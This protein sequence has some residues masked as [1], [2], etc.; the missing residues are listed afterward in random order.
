MSGNNTIKFIARGSRKTDCLSEWRV[1]Q[2]TIIFVH[3]SLNRSQ[4][5][6]MLLCFSATTGHKGETFL[7]T[8]RMTISSILIRWTFISTPNF[9]SCELE[10]SLVFTSK[11]PCQFCA[12]RLHE[13]NLVKDSIRVV[14]NTSGA[15]ILRVIL[16]LSK[17]TAPSIV[18]R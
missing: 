1:G 2:I 14:L 15:G 6:I 16:F 9:D 18:E 4:I 13:C 12:F 17:L 5:S 7:S 8:K 3:M 10:F 11:C